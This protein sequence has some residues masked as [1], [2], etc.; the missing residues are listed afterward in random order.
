MTYINVNFNT[1]VKYLI[2]EREKEKI[3]TYQIINILNRNTTSR[4][5]VGKLTVWL[6]ISLK[7][8][9]ESDPASRR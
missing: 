5:L 8:V 7:D 2:L 1:I 4:N 3:C 6:Y 9:S